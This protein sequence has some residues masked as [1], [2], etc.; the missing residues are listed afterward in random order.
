VRGKIG[1]YGNAKI[2]LKLRANMELSQ[3]LV[4]Y[5]EYYEEQ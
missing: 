4:E 1:V 5:K 3:G 2:I